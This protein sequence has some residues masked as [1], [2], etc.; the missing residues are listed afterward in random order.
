LGTLILVVGILVIIFGAITLLWGI[1]AL[2]LGS[3]PPTNSALMVGIVFTA[4]GALLIRK[5][6]AD[7]KKEKNS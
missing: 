7:K 4:I 5:Y 1:I 2:A 3:L 6:D